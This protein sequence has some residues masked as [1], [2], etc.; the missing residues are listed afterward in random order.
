MSSVTPSS[1]FQVCILGGG[2]AGCATALALSRRGIGPVL[3]VESGGYERPRVGE[4]IPPDT[5][6]LLEQLGVWERFQAEGHEPCL[7]N[8]SWWGGERIGHNDFLFNPYGNGWHLDRTRFDRFLA[9]EAARRGVEVRTRTRLTGCGPAGPEGRTLTLED[10]RQG[11]SRAESR[12]E[13]RFVVDAT[14]TKS[15]FARRMGARRL[16]LDRLVCVYGFFRLPASAGFTRLTTLEAVEDG[17]WY[18]ARLPSQ[19]LAVA[20]AGDSTFIRRARLL[21]ASRWLALLDRTR[22]LSGL[23]A[24]SAVLDGALVLRPAPSFRLDR[25]HGDGWLAVGDAAS[26]Y[27][28]L[29]SQ[30]IY[31]ALSDGIT[32]AEVISRTR[33]GE[34]HLGDLH[35]TRIVARFDDYRRSR[36]FFYGLEGRW[37][38]SP[39]WAARQSGRRNDD[40][41]DQGSQRKTGRLAGAVGGVA[42]GGV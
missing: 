8:R 29:S 25:V 18:A 27:D 37:P 11:E 34:R 32:A 16:V 6:L 9:D 30:G 1:R 13:A 2:P 39:F 20:F 15:R 21:E 4:S 12:A 40:A 38:T 14:G 5:R 35:Q 36:S 17:W 10:T 24:D 23:L 22:H 3:L 28:P 7:G 31:K 26:A 33:G 41:L 42:D 19:R